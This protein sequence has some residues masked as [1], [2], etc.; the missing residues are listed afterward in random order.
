[1]LSRQ[2]LWHWARPL[3]AFVAV[4]GAAWLFWP[5]A[6]ETPA[7]GIDPAAFARVLNSDADGFADADGDWQFDFPRDQGP[8]P[9]HR[10]EVWDLSGLLVDDRGRRYGLRLTFV[11]IGLAPP[12]RQRASALAANAVMLARLVLLPEVGEGGATAQRLSRAAGGLAG[13]EAAPFRVWVEDWS[14]A[15]GEGDV[16]VLRADLDEA[17]LLL[18]LTPSKPVVTD[19]QAGLFAAADAG[20]DSAQGPGFHFY[21]QPRLTVEGRLTLG[22]RAGTDVSVGSLADERSIPHQPTALRAPSRPASDSTGSGEPAQVSVLVEGTAWLE[23][24]WGSVSGG[25]AGQR[26]QL[27]LNRFLLQ[28][29]DGTELMCLHLRRRGGGG[30]PIPTCL[31]IA[32]DGNTRLF[33][34]RE[35][36]LEPGNGA[37]SSPQDGARYP[38]WWRLTLPA[39]GLD[40]ALE[41]LLPQQE[42]APGMASGGRIWSGLVTLSGSRDGEPVTGGGR[43]DLSGYAVGSGT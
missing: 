22:P 13:A 28:L 18:R 21:L 36:T 24:A 12:A 20:A 15:Q 41:P 34:R 11:R 3:L 43:M 10:G 17:R 33:Q 30:T 25:L 39:L 32:R 31:G 38:L 42:L 16:L 4:A 37:W 7:T 8:H 35:L 1:M 5:N 6:T 26:G 2:S 40:V 23:H 14:L 29:D 19:T 9:D 27:S